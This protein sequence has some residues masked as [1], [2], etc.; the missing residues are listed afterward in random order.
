MWIELLDTYDME[1][2][3]RS[4]ARHGNAGSLSKYPCRQCGLLDDSK[5]ERCAEVAASASVGNKTTSDV[6]PDS[7][8]LNSFRDEDRKLSRIEVPVT[9]GKLGN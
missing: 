6:N 5:T 2:K 1:I 9:V 3:H 4:G 8:N 7:K